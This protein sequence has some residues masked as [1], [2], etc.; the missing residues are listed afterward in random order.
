MMIYIMGNN[1]FIKKAD[2]FKFKFDRKI[3]REITLLKV[4][5]VVILIF[6]F[7]LAFHK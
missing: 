5:F 7:I 2:E 1:S 3:Y 4:N 6:H